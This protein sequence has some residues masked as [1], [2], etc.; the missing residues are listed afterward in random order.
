M[1]LVL[2]SCDYYSLKKIRGTCKPMKRMLDN[3]SVFDEALFRNRPATNRCL[4]TA[5]QK[6]IKGLAQA[7]LARAFF[8]VHPL[9]PKPVRWREDLGR[10]VSA[11][12][13]V[14]PA[15]NQLYWSSE[16]SWVE[17]RLTNTTTVEDVPH[18][19]NE[20]ATRPPVSELEVVLTS[21]LSERNV[22][23]RVEF[24]GA[25]SLR[26][27]PAPAPS[28][29]LLPGWPSPP[30]PVRV[31]DL[32]STLVTLSH[33]WDEFFMPEDPN[34]DPDDETLFR[35]NTPPQLEIRDDGLLVV[36]FD[37]CLDY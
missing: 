10:P 25:E 16:N 14:H 9:A 24:G 34:Q 20:C 22:R 37:S 26:G 18:I 17:A 6:Q 30:Q 15:I 21:Q 27:A 31:K 2:L 28:A 19:Q 23:L 5:D 13:D 12:L 3:D 32:I 1:K 29:P 7:R 33:E 11:Y 4:T 36:T 35:V 8:T